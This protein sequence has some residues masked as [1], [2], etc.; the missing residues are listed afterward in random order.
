MQRK[1]LTINSRMAALGAAAVLSTAV[2]IGF[3][4]VWLRTPHSDLDQVRA[5][6]IWSG[7]LKDDRP[8]IIVVGDYYLIGDTDS[9][10]DVKR[11]IREYSVNSKSDLDDYILQ[12]SEVA[13]RFMDVGLRY[14]PIASAFALRNVMAVLAPENRRISVS[15]MSDVQPGSLKSADIVYIGFIS[16]LGKMQELVFTGP[17]FAVG[18]SYDEVVDKKTHHSYISQTWDQIVVPVQPSGTEKSYHDYGIFAKFRG[19]G[20][21]I[22]VV[23]SGTQDAGVQQ[24]AEAFTSAEKLE[25]FGQQADTTLPFEALLEVSAF[26]GVNLSGK[27]VLES[28]RDWP[29]APCVTCRTN[30]N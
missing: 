15:K 19:P 21:N 25:E 24:T 6:P 26:D 27:L 2:L 17:R 30:N 11:L 29:N 16:G 7:I 18:D 9:S 1:T 20:G 28:K 12:H 22:I 3:G 23:I 13:D 4:I 5:N 8:I 10:M 14:L